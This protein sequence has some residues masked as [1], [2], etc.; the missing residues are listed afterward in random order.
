MTDYLDTAIAA[1]RA[2]GEI[3]ARDF[4]TRPETMRKGPI[5]LVTKT[6]LEAEEAVV[7]IL[8]GAFPSHG[9][10]AEERDPYN[11]DSEFLWLVDPLDGTT[12]FAHSYPVVA[13]AI[14]LMRGDEIILGVVL[15]PLRGDLFTAERS[16]GAI[17]NGAPIRV[18]DVAV[19]DDSLVCTGFPYS[20]REDP[21]DNLANFSKFCLRAQGVRR[22]GAAALDLCHVA[23]G[24]FDGFWERGLKP[25]DTAA[26]TLIL[27][28]SGGTA[29]DFSGNE[30]NPFLNEIAAS[31]GKIHDEMLSVLNSG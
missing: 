30:F 22:D 19:V 26:G 13:V 7:S 10:L 2:A 31:N 6:D 29:T 1:A 23:A 21:G 20:I 27:R 12:N 28:E 8:R 17:L 11:R 9:I 14:A 25:W 3:I 18:S 16:A 4:G 5:D 24:R 15:E